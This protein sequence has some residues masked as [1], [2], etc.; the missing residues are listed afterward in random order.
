MLKIDEAKLFLTHKLIIISQL[1]LD[2]P[3]FHRQQEDKRLLS[4]IS[5]HKKVFFLLLIYNNFSSRKKE[6]SLKIKFS[7]CN[8]LI[9]FLKKKYFIGNHKTEK[10]FRIF[11]FCFEYFFTND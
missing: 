10:E 6:N 7:K 8:F 4:Q 9:L 5:I 1:T 3:H 2:H 11:K